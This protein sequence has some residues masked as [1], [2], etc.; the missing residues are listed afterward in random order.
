MCKFDS[1]GPADPPTKH[2]SS[3]SLLE[4]AFEHHRIK[5]KLGSYELGQE[6]QATQSYC[7][8]CL[9]SSHA[10]DRK[11]QQVPDQGCR[12][13]HP[14]HASGLHQQKPGG[15]TKPTD[16]LLTVGEVFFPALADQAQTSYQRSFIFLPSIKSPEIQPYRGNQ[17]DHLQNLTRNNSIA[18]LASSKQ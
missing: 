14:K 18:D 10:V 17:A 7:P 11:L 6:T 13:R 5:R 4:S 15:P 2:R 9:L 3:P 1:P 12:Q 8:V 16:D